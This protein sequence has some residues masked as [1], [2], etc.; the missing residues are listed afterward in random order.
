MYLAALHKFP[1][2]TASVCQML[3]PQAATNDKEYNK[4]VR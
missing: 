1:T 3:T 2:Q 4:K